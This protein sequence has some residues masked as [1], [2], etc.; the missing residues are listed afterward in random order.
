[1]ACPALGNGAAPR[2]QGIVW[3]MMEHDTALEDFALPQWLK[4]SA[5]MGIGFKFLLKWSNDL[6]DMRVPPF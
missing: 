6:D 5:N 3:R 2:V 1:M 4:S